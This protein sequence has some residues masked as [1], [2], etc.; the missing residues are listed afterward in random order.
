MLWG[1][2]LSGLKRNLTVRESSSTNAIENFVSFPGSPQILY[3]L[4]FKRKAKDYTYLYGSSLDDEESSLTRH[5]KDAFIEAAD[6]YGPKNGLLT[7]E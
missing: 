7:A 1:G 2:K 6:E 5:L 3:Q 4:K